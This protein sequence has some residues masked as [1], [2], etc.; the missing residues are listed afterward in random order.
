[1]TDLVV[2]T[3]GTKGIGA[4]VARQLVRSG[5][6]V[7]LGYRSDPERA[8]ELVE[9]LTAAGGVAQAHRADVTDARQVAA[10]FRAAEAMG[11]LVG[12]VNNAGFLETQSSFL[13]I[14][15]ERWRRVFDTNVFGVVTCTHE[16]VRR[17]ATNSGGQGGSIVNVSSRASQLGSPHEYIDYA[18]SKG[19]L[20]SMTRGLALEVAPLGIRVNG[21]R[22]GIIDTDL[23]TR[24]GE[25]GRAARLGPSIPVG[26]EGTA[27]E[28]A[29]AICWL[30]T[31]ASS[32]V[33]GTFID[34]SGGR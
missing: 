34:V 2:I 19:A 21:V 32:Y 29:E 17:M 25:P 22:P 3:G 16:A 27:E 4:A 14:D 20:D 31:P 10:L 1:M 7:C 8:D 26:R 5:Y 24:G 13:G 6:A 23:H 15:L 18:A 11:D 12:L 9:E 33:T 30:L 28:V